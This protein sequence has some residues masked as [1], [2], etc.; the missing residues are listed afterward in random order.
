MIG[1]YKLLRI[2]QEKSALLMAYVAELIAGAPCYA[3]LPA[4][5]PLAAFGA[6]SWLRAADRPLDWIRASGIPNA[7]PSLHLATDGLRLVC[8]GKGRPRVFDAVPC[9]YGTQHPDHR[10]ALRSAL[11]PRPWFS[12][13]PC[14]GPLC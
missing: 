4:M 5:G 14:C 2:L 8:P 9:W 12:I 1:W 3:V 11:P 10:R 6:R 7:I 13:L